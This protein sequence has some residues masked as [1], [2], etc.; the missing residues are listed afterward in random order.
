M[1]ASRS[2]TKGGCPCRRFTYYVYVTDMEIDHSHFLPM[3]PGDFHD[4]KIMVKEDTVNNVIM[5]HHL[6]GTDG[7]VFILKTAL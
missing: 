5:A 4:Q 3:S 2:A 6:P 7:T 1:I